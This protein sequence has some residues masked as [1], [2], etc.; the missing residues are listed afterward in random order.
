MWVTFD[1]AVKG[2]PIWTPGEEAPPPDRDP[3]RVGAGQQEPEPESELGADGGVPS[4][5][6]LVVVGDGGVGCSAFVEQ[7]VRKRFRG[8]AE[9]DAQGLSAGG[10]AAACSG[11]CRQVRVDGRPVLVLFWDVGSDERSESCSAVYSQA[12]AVLVLYDVGRRSTFDGVEGWVERVRAK[13]RS[14]VVPVAVVGTKLDLPVPGA[15][16]G[17]RVTEEEAW[18]LAERLGTLQFRTSSKTGQMINEAVTRV[19][20]DALTFVMLPPA[21]PLPPEWSAPAARRQKKKRVLAGLP[22]SSAR[23]AEAA[24]ESLLQQKVLISASP[25][26]RDERTW[27]RDDKAER[28][29]RCKAAFNVL[30]RRHHCRMCGC[31][32]CHSC[33]DRTFELE[34]SEP[35]SAPSVRAP[36]IA[37]FGW[38]AASLAPVMRG[39][40]LGG[41]PEGPAAA[42]TTV[43]AERVCIDCYTRLESARRE[44]EVEEARREREVEETVKRL[45]ALQAATGFFPDEDDDE[46]CTAKALVSF[47]QQYAVRARRPA[48][49]GPCADGRSGAGC[50]TTRSSSSTVWTG[51]T[52]AA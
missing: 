12:D 33:S 11:T 4:M 39:Q 17:G 21:E 2:P 16:A 51:R 31:V 14:S 40:P 28:C 36:S 13:C 6:Q 22:R 29:G 20:A 3:S 18:A 9:E 10:T 26:R 47:V 1:A 34:S 19:V 7:W 27:E 32:F 24:V 48:L 41:S 49:A 52:G 5:L 37:A 45:S 50:R 30:R 38:F 44:R 35:A 23:S 25:R 8:S 43:Q 15:G 42:A 46:N